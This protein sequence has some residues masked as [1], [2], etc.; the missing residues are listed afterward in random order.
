LKT[1]FQILLINAIILSIIWMAIRYFGLTPE[2]IWHLAIIE[3]IAFTVYILCIFQLKQSWLSYLL[4]QI[5]IG[6]PTFEVSEAN[7]S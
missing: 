3:I 6:K 4:Y 5:G 1:V 2:S 7:K